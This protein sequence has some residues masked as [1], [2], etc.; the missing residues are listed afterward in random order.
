MGLDGGAGAAL[1]QRPWEKAPSSGTSKGELEAVKAALE[2]LI[3][4]ERNGT[5]TNGGL[6]WNG[7]EWVNQLAGPESLI[8]PWLT[9]ANTQ[10]GP[11][12]RLLL[13]ANNA[14]VLG[15]VYYT[16]FIAE[17]T[18]KFTK[19]GLYVGT[20]GEA[21]TLARMGFYTVGETFGV[22]LAAHTANEVGFWTAT[23]ATPK[24]LV[25]NNLDGTA[26]VFPIEF[27]L[28]RGTLYVVSALAV[29]GV[30][31]TV[32]GPSVS[33]VAGQVAVQNPPLVGA[34]AGQADIGGGNK[35]EN[36]ITRA[37]M[38]GSSICPGFFLE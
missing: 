21:N 29:G 24:P 25:S 23:G 33:T 10:V 20:K 34:V 7:A 35:G 19:M 1:A 6:Y 30:G 16:S 27:E 12:P 5:V 32:R 31:P 36:E 14:M 28:I 3:P 9:P 18:R 8:L 22:K 11:I 4:K 15:T 2:A 38:V 26:G 37:A 17:K 13:S